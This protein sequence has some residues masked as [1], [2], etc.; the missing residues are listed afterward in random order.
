MKKDREKNNAT[1]SN[2]KTREYKIYSDG[3]TFAWRNKEYMIEFSDGSFQANDESGYVDDIHTGALYLY[4]TVSLYKKVPT[5]S[6]NMKQKK[7]YWKKIGETRA[8]DFPAIFGLEDILEKVLNEKDESGCQ[9]DRMEDRDGSEVLFK[10][11]TME[12]GGM[13]SEDYYEI[14]RTTLMEEGDD[15]GHTRYSLYVGCG[16]PMYNVGCTDGFMATGIKRKGIKMLLKCVRGF[17][18]YIRCEHN[19][20]TRESIFEDKTCFFAEDG[21]LYK[22]EKDNPGMS[23]YIPGD[24]IGGMT[25]LLGDAFGNSFSSLDIARAAIKN[26]TDEHIVLSGGYTREMPDEK[27]LS[28]NGITYTADETKDSPEWTV[29]I[30]RILYIMQDSDSGPRKITDMSEMA[31]DFIKRIGADEAQKIISRPMSA[32]VSKW[33]QIIADTYGLARNVKRK[34]GKDVSDYRPVADAVCKI[35]RLTGLK[36]V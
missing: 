12:S 27:S 4:Y 6:R 20:Q 18:E 22:R 16:I 32:S 15:K 23:I 21:R 26:I 30:E 29:P 7:G 3:G 11:R 36:E 5:Y 25:A 9:T 14:T 10:S 28:E 33:G 2:K 34:Y 24:T 1:G 8:Y 19:R 35:I 31:E 17:L 13:L